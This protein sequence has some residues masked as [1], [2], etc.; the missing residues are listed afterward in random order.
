MADVYCILLGRE[1]LSMK[2]RGGE[3]G[4]PTVKTVCMSMWVFFSFPFVF[5][6]SKWQGRTL[7]LLS[8]LCE[9]KA[10]LMASEH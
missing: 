10:E 9:G 8:I 1:C 2:G 6:P 4:G 3:G 5:L 7:S